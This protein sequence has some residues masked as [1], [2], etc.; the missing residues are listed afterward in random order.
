MFFVTLCVF[1]C[2]YLANKRL[3]Q[4]LYVSMHLHIR[5]DGWLV[6]LI[7]IY[8]YNYLIGILCPVLVVVTDK[9][10]VKT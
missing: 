5:T 8:I 9:T 4:I 1:S 7:F 10:N 2:I 3:H 6:K